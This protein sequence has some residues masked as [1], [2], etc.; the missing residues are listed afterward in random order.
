M[1]SPVGCIV[2][3]TEEKSKMT[4]LSVYVAVMMKGQLLTT[5]AHKLD[6]KTCSW[7]RQRTAKTV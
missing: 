3:P 2:P 7:V 4:W 6:A 5:T 1:T